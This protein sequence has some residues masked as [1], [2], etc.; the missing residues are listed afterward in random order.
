MTKKGVGYK[1][2]GPQHICIP[3]LKFSKI[4]RCLLHFS[5]ILKTTFMHCI[6]NKQSSFSTLSKTRAC[7]TSYCLII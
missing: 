5:H 3:E 6:T 1:I 2:L 7:E 4:I